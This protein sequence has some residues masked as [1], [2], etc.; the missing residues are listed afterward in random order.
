MT[1]RSR[2][3]HE[4]SRKITV[5][6]W[7][8]E[9]TRDDDGDANL[10]AAVFLAQV[11]WW[12]ST[13]ERS[14]RC[15]AAHEHGAHTWLVRADNEWESELGLSE[16]TV[17]R[18]R[19]RLQ[20]LK[21]IECK[22]LID[23]SIRCTHIRRIWT[24]AE[25]STIRPET[26]DA[27][28]ST[29]RPELADQ[30]RPDP[31]DADADQTPLLAV[32]EMTDQ[33]VSRAGAILS[34]REV[35]VEVP[36]PASPSSAAPRATD[37]PRKRKAHELTVLAFEQPIKPTLRN[38]GKGAFPAVMAI[39]HELLVAGH[40]VGDIERA[41][42]QGITVWTIGGIQTSIA[43]N[44]PNGYAGVDAELDAARAAHGRAMAAEAV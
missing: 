26:A 4:D 10:A 27:E 17:R 28:Q 35:V 32:S 44:K 22:T 3:E 15:R 38:G 37:D 14:G 11:T 18:L 42:R 20:E 12:L 1:V 29:I 41:I 43:R 33:A 25:P 24:D 8:I 2:F 34:E 16:R 23:K 30:K 6:R 31:A 7:M 36:P 21:L 13:S 19:R 5:T 39:F 9:A 40:V